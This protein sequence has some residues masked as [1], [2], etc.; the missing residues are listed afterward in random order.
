MIPRVEEIRVPP[1]EYLI[2]TNTGG[3]VAMAYD[4]KQGDT[5]VVFFASCIRKD[6]KPVDGEERLF[7]LL[8]LDMA[9]GIISHLRNSLREAG[10]PDALVDSKVAANLAVLADMDINPEQYSGGD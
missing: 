8:D 2:P 4:R 3:G 7:F 9:T 6:G 10:V 1:E 5:L